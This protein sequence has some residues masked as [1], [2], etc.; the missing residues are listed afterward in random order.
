MITVVIQGGL[1]NQL[2]QYAYGRALMMKGKD[3]IFDISFFDKETK[4]TKRN[5]QLDKFLLS[6]RIKTTKKSTK[7][8][9]AVRILNKI[10]VD[11]KVRYVEVNKESDDYLADGYYNTEKYFSDFRKV[12]LEEVV[13]KEKSEVYNTWEQRILQNE[14]SLIIHARRADYKNATGFVSLDEAY[15]KKALK[16]FD[17]NVSIFAF[18]DDIAWLSEVLGK[19]VIAVSGQGLTDY[20]EMVLMSKGKNF[21]IAN[22]TF[23]W[24]GAWLSEFKDKKVVAPKKW[25]TSLWWGKADKD[26]VPASWIRV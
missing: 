12:I 24:W 3:V 26:I 10:D 25:F 6:N 2:F 8:N 9:L 7:Q 22:S 13:L 19:N 4:Y 20:E 14:K 1:G 23:S 18:S 16:Q 11:R 5:Y 17:S 21:I 15:Y